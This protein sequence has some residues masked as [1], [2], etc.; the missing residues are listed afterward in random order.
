MTERLRPADMAFLTSESAS[1]PMHNATLEV[2]EPARDGFDYERLVALI[3]DRIA[4]V[5]KYRQRVRSIPG[6]VANP[7]W[8]DDE[9]FDL[10]YHVRRSALPRPGSMGQLR[11]LVARIM[12]RR[13]DRNR[14]LWEV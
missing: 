11:E 4:F 1:A 6:R 13:L 7:V 2:F 14:P 8:L 10:I 5:P 12:S 3:A 9:D